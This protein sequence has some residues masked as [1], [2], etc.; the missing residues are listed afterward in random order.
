MMQFS[1]T[2]TPSGRSLVSMFLPED[3]IEGSQL[4]ALVADLGC[5]EPFGLSKA[6]VIESKQYD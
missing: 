3:A 4:G 5:L 2:I 6:A 1:I